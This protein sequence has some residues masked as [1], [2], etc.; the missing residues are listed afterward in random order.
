MSQPAEDVPFAVRTDVRA[1]HLRVLVS[2][3]LDL[4]REAELRSA[5][6]DVLV[7]RAPDRLVL[8]VC[9][10]QFLDSSGLRALLNCRDRARSVG[11][12]LTLAVTPGP[13]TRLLDLAGVRDWFDY[14]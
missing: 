7:D 6:N 2:G 3:E 14:E 13:V 9:G 12:P 8:D 11:V 4:Y 5:V 1:D 10:L